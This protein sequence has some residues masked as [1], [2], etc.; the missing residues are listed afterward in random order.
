[1]HLFHLCQESPAPNQAL[2]K[3]RE[4][5]YLAV[6][7]SVQSAACPAA[8][9]QAAVL[10][11]PACPVMAAA[12]MLLEAVPGV[13]GAALVAAPGATVE[14]ASRAAEADKAAYPRPEARTAPVGALLALLE[15]LLRE[16][17]PAATVAAHHSLVRGCR[18]WENQ[19]SSLAL[20]HQRQAEAH[21][22]HPED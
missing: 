6:A 2:A 9:N 10:L 7:E 21:P 11:L 19:V 3:V 13:L 5:L 20:Q 17:R 18:S 8:D 1:M 15:H 12:R 22:P 4:A 16:G 14:A